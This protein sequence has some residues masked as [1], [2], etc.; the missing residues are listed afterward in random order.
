MKPVNK[1]EMPVLITLLPFVLLVLAF[2]AVPLAAMVLD[3]F[4]GDSGKGWTLMQYATVFGNKFY[5]QA[6]KNSIVISL[7]SSIAGLLVSMAAAY[8][9]TRLPGKIQETVL[10]F[11]NMTSNFVGVPLAFAYIVLLGNN[12]LFTMLFAKWGW[13]IFNGFDLYSWTGLVLVYIYFQVP[14]AILLLYPAF[15]GIR[16]QWKEAA[17]LLGASRPEFWLHVGIPVILPEIAGT[18]TILFANSMGAYA[19]A[20][21]LVGG[22]YNLLTVRIGSLVAGNVFTNPQLAGA[23]AVF[24][25]ATMLG[26]MWLN[27]LLLRRIRRDMT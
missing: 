14:L 25:A 13:S 5:L 7:Y 15:F 17:Y 16:E 20:F 2:E 22:N 3:S 9:F 4:R 1:R 8:S 24:L 26:A 11:S 27:S 21:A 18:F 12:G 10:M 19:T 6:I 23:L